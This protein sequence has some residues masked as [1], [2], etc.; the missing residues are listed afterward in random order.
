MRVLN[1]D[2]L[3]FAVQKEDIM[4]LRGALVTF[5]TS[6]G[7]GEGAAKAF[8]CMAISLFTPEQVKKITNVHLRTP[9]HGLPEDDVLETAKQLIAWRT[10]VHEMNEVAKD[11]H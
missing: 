9:E 8:A 11:V 5:L 10:L 3:E 7:A 1:Q 4:A 2:V 6:D